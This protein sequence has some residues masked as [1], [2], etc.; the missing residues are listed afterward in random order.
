MSRKK[1]S[2]TGC[3]SPRPALRKN[4]ASVISRHGRG[5]STWLRLEL[6]RE[7]QFE[8]VCRCQWRLPRH[9]WKRSGNSE[10]V[11]YI[12]QDSVSLSTNIPRGR[13][14]LGPGEPIQRPC[15]ASGLSE[16]NQD[17]ESIPTSSHPLLHLREDTAPPLQKSRAIDSRPKLR[18]RLWTSFQMEPQPMRSVAMSSVP[19]PVA[20][21]WLWLRPR[22]AQ[23]RIARFNV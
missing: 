12:E 20:G 17:C 16:P 5:L 14:R 9:G 13:L 22:C 7:W 19:T 21:V 11:C 18:Q 8:L 10:S 1:F 23:K 6:S 15:R 4:I 3:V 2:R